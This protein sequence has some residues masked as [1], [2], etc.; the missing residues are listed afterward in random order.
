MAKISGFTII[1]NA[2]INDYPIAEAICSVLPVV[3]EMIVAVGNCE[4]GTEELIRSIPSDKIKIFHS[5]WAPA[6]FKGGKIL[7]VETDK[8]FQHISPG[9]DWAFYIQAD[10]VVHEKYHSLIIEAAEKYRNDKS[11]EGLVFN[12]LHF[13][14]TYDYVG[15]SRKWYRREIRMIRNDKNISSYRDAQ[16]FRKNEKK[17]KAKLIDAYIYHY[18][19]VKNPEKMLV[20]YLNL[21]EFW[22]ESVAE[23]EYLRAQQVFN[24]DDFD[25]L[26][27]F[28]GTH[29]AIM[30]KRIAD[31]NWHVEL[32]ISQK[33]FSLKE[34]LLYWLEK[35]SGRRLFEFRNY[36][37]A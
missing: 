16:G 28:N 23:K 1:R 25:S 12:Y 2:V 26:T 3:D 14:G 5:V 37:L 32:D 33:K 6:H 13:Y 10:E 21:G 9:S 15:D 30:Q 20:K 18:G 31:K 17:L 11:I 24:F 22:Q 19:W 4:D 8:A 35:K 27:K 29:P 36:K 34:R 7:A